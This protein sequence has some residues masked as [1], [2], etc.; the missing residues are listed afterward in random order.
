VPEFSNK[1]NSISDENEEFL[2]LFLLEVG[3]AFSEFF[4]HTFFPKLELVLEW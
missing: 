1:G 4:K 2:V 3:K